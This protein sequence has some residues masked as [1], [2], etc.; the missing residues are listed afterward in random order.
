M[1]WQVQPRSDLKIKRSGRERALGEDGVPLRWQ[2]EDA[3]FR[4]QGH[5]RVER[6]GLMYG[7]A[8][9]D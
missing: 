7:I 6:E 1:K 4:N 8:A 3:E 2:G 5:C 9:F